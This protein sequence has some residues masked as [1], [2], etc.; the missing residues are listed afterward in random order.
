MYVMAI[1]MLVPLLMVAFVPSEARYASTFVFT[2][3]L[4]GAIGFLLRNAFKLKEQAA[5]DFN[6]SS[7]VVFLTWAILSVAGAIPYMAISGMSFAHAV[8]DSISGWTTTGLSLLDI[9]KAPVIILFYRAWAQFVGGAGIAIIMLASLTGVGSQQ[10]YSAEGK[11]TLIKPNVL[12]SARIVLNL[13]LGYFIAGTVAY[14]I[15]GMSLF[16][17][18]VHCF[19]A[20]STG[21]FSNYVQ[22]MGYFNSPAIEF[23][24]MVLMILGNLSFLMGYFIVKGKFRHIWRNGEVRVLVLS[25]LVSIPVIFLA[26]T[27]RLYSSASFAFRDA[28]FEAVSALTTTGFSLVNYTQPMWFDSGIFILTL[29]MLIGGGTCSTAGGIKQYRIYM[30]YKSVLWNIK[31]SLMPSHAVSKKYVWEGDLKSYPD[32]S[33]FRGIANFVFLYLSIYVV[34]VIILALSTNPVTGAP[35]SLRDAMFEFASSLGTVGISIG[36]S[37]PSAPLQVIWAESIGMLLGRLEIYV[38][39]LAVIKLIRDSTGRISIRRNAQRTR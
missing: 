36:V 34:G 5:L 19:A 21:G 38:V 28:C 24:S 20:I 32:A 14:L 17:A 39:F 3:A 26:V 30:L 22:N 9:P 7:V 16:D 13:Y 25:L 10:I 1:V 33:S 27:S 11:G 18:V 31:A 4:L 23:V 29:L 8:F 35:Y 12:A 6:E 37:T 2:A 15:C